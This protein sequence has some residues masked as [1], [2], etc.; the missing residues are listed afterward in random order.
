M[1]RTI[2]SLDLELT[3]LS[4]E[5]DQI[6][7]FAALKFDEDTKNVIGK[8]NYFIQPEGEYSI[9]LQAFLKHGIKPEF[10]K[11]KPYFK[12]VAHNIKE[13]LDGCTIL[14]YNGTNCDIPFLMYA[15]E[16]AGIEWN[17]L[18]FEYFDAFMEEKRRNGNK[19]EETFERYFGVSMEKAGL[20]AHDAYSDVMATIK[21][22]YE[23]QKIEKYAPF[24]PLTADNFI[25]IMPFKNK[26]VACFT[27]G[28]YRDLPV[29]FVK[30]IDKPYIEW[31]VSDRATFCEST[32][33]YIRKNFL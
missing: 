26:E 30:T 27:I 32:K 21:V 22:Y 14:T 3:G 13:F 20:Q 8:L 24:K 12:D 10:L 11:D 29:D 16:R 4:K 1:G 6:I 9:T 15:F 33:D 23:Q 18:E 28:K 2:V 31:C 19:L 25:K 5:K 17:P 7:Q